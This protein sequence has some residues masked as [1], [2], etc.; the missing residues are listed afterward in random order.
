M[1][2]IVWQPSYKKFCKQE[3]IKILSLNDCYSIKNL[4]F[5]SLH[6]D[7]IIQ[8]KKFK[9]KKLFNLHFSLLPAYRGMH[10]SAFPLLN[11]EKYSGVTIH[12]IDDGI[13]TGDIISQKKFKI[14]INY[15]ARDLFLKYMFN[16]NILF[17]NTIDLLIN[18]T[19]QSYP[20]TSVESSYFNK[21]SINFFKYFYKS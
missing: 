19:Y 8:T 7:K 12:K 9:S 2:S 14:H 21:A 15:T 17:Q 6:Y 13:D 3:G 10:T 11:G 4:I 20:Q 5:I 1:E 18:N 16:G